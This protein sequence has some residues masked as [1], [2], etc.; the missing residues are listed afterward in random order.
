[1]EFPTSIIKTTKAFAHGV[2][3][4]LAEA[5]LHGLQAA[6]EAHAPQTAAVA[7]GSRAAEAVGTLAERLLLRFHVPAAAAESAST[8]LSASGGGA[9]SVV[10]ATL[11]RV[12]SKLQ[13]GVGQEAAIAAA[14]GFK[15]AGAGIVAGNVMEASEAAAAHLVR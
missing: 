5:T 3:A 1:M 11:E 15:G 8:A 7:A 2:G 4:E 9:A 14:G 6:N 12:A 13:P 10:G